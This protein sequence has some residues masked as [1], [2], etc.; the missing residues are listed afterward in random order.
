MQV[1]QCDSVDKQT[2]MNISEIVRFEVFAAQTM[3]YDVF[4]DIKT[5]FVLHRKQLF[6]RYRAL[7]VNSL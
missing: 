1:V 2:R 7:P 5:Q 6:L 4:W 3:K